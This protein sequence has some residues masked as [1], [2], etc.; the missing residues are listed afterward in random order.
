[1]RPRSSAVEQ[2]R[3]TWLYTV[4]TMMSRIWRLPA[5]TR[6]AYD[7]SSLRTVWHLAA[8]CPAWLKEAWIGWLGPDV[9]WELYAGTEAQ[10]RTDISGREWL[11]HRG[12]PSS[13]PRRTWTSTRCDGTWLTGWRATRTPGPSRSSRPRC[14]TRPGKCAGPSCE[15]TGSPLRRHDLAAL[16]IPD[17]YP[18]KPVE[19]SAGPDEGRCG[20][21]LARVACSPGWIWA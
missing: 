2:H 19:G 9:I 14:A 17:P 8:P 7:L 18:G 4:P 12:T 11:E 13:R 1:M 10:A 21:W 15:P 5:E 6:S 20:A 3:A 16:F